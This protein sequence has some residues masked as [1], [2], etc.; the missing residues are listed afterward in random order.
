MQ[1]P[2]LLLLVLLYLAG[3][4]AVAQ[5]TTPLPSDVIAANK[6]LDHQLIE[7]HRLLDTDG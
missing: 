4:L 3:T 1:K 7:G 2:F 5:T 6:D